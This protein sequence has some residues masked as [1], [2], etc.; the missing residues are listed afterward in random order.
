MT[1]ENTIEFFRKNVYGNQYMYVADKTTASHIAVL[2]DAL[3]L[4][5]SAKKALEALGFTFV[6]VLAPTSV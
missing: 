4:L 3:T 2:T 1:N 5:P 6:E